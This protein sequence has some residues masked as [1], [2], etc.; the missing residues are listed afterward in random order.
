VP[1]RRHR[2]LVEG[3][4]VESLDKRSD[5]SRPD[6]GIGLVNVTDATR[7]VLFIPDELSEAIGQ[8]SVCFEVIQNDTMLASPRTKLCVRS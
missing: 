5:D 3:W 1:G 4:S 8:Y 7:Y 2:Y 6:I